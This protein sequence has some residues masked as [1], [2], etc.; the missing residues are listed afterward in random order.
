MSIVELINNINKKVEELDLVTA[1]KLIEENIEPLKE[2]RTKLKKNARELFEFITQA[3]DSGYKSPTKQELFIISAINSQAT[4]FDLRG[5]KQTI[6]GNE[7]LLLNKVA[8]EFLNSDA[9]VLLEGMGAI[10]KE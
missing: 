2:N 1:R 9:K 8:R 6:K 5:L 4:K 3:M 7:H 10:T